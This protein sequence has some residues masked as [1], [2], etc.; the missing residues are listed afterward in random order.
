MPALAVAGALLAWAVGFVDDARHLDPR[1]KLAAE[2]P[3]LV[4]GSFAI[5]LDGAVR[6]VAIVVGLFL[7]NAFNVIDGL[8]ALAG[9]TAAIALAAL[10]LLNAPLAALAAVALGGVLAFLVFNLPPARLFLGD[11]GSLLLGYVLWLVPLAAFAAAPS[12]RLLIVTG[13]LWAFPLVN[14]GFVVLARIR[15]RRPVLA[16][17]RSH[18][19]DVLHRRLGL[20]GTLLVCWTIGAA[21][22]IGAAALG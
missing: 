18:L 11:E 14:A 16:G 4:V 8:D 20:R 21:G 22:A 5:D 17:D 12:A 13:C 3:A 9:G 6:L 10:L 2:L 7:I 19:Y 1:L 15:A